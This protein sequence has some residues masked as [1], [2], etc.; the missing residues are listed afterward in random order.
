MRV[1]AYRAE[2]VPRPWLCRVTSRGRR[3][4]ISTTSYT[5]HMSPCGHRILEALLGLTLCAL[6]SGCGA[7]G[8]AA[9]GGLLLGSSFSSPKPSPPR[10]LC[11]TDDSIGLT[12]G[13][14]G[15]SSHDEAM[16]LISEHCVSGYIETH[17][18]YYTTTCEVFVACLQ[19]DGSPP[20]SPSC[21]FISPEQSPIGFGNDDPSIDK[22][23]PF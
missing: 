3:N 1:A 17:R 7:V 13:T 10:V 23:Q 14:T 16:R 19:A 2:P 20:H 8:G 6:L 11:A 5:N 15:S 22:G 4:D 9:I 12:Y 18:V 21:K